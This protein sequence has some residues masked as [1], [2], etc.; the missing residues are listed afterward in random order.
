MQTD[1]FDS[2]TWKAQRGASATA[3]K[4]GSM[5]AALEAAVRVGMPRA[6]VIRLLGEPDLRDT[7]TNSD[8]YMV[9]LATGPDE[10]YY[11]IQYKDGN[12]A[13]VRFGQF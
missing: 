5:G 2:D 4:R 8:Q 9:G 11:E 7:E 12:V 13:S 1:S 6:D 3:N 10:Q